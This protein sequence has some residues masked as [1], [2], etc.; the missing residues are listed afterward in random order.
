MRWPGSACVAVGLGLAMLAG[1]SLPL[2]RGVHVSHDVRAEQRDPGDIEVL[3]PGPRQRANPVDI[4]QG[5]LGAESSPENGHAIARQYLTADAH[6][7]DNEVQV[8][9]PA[10]L[11]V[12]ESSSDPSSAT[13]A[14]TFTKLGL[15]G[16]DGA[17]SDLVPSPVKEGYTLVR[18]RAGDW[19]ISS[20]P[21]GLRLTPADRDRSFRPRRLFY[22]SP[23]PKA[24]L[25]VVPDLVLLPVATGQ[26]QAAIS[27]LLQPP[28]SALQGSVTTA[29]PV[30]TRLLSL[31][32]E[33]G[34]LYDVNLSAELEH[35]SGPQ[36]QGLSAQLVWTLRGLDPRFESLRV[37]AAGKPFAVPSEGEVQKAEDWNVLDPEGLADGPL[38]FIGGG[39]L[40]T[41]TSAGRVGAGPAAS[42]GLDVDRAA[43]TPDRTQIALLHRDGG[44]VTVRAGPVSSDRYPVVLRAPG[45]SSPTWGSGE[46][47]LWLLDGSGHVL[48]LRGTGRA[49]PVVVVGLSTRIRSIAV[50]RDGARVAL[51]SDGL[52]YVGRI[53]KAA[54]GAPVVRPVLV[55]PELTGVTRVGWRDGTTLV[56]LGV[57]MD[58]FV[59]VLLSVDGSSVRSLAVSG[60]PSKPGELAAS[61]LG[62]V[63]TASGQL[64]VLSALGFQAGPPGAAPAYPG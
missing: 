8:Y 13:V 21:F 62:T 41:V 29:F 6:W 30:G 12:A 35:A 43:V 42:A 10:S 48:L 32:A 33:P 40:K 23:S 4:V 9:D 59:P 56:A 31:R 1:C 47:G 60:L 39:R 17:Y 44:T 22:L 45:L 15:L 50:S 64:F 54:N 24:T 36:R 7:A 55:A 58:T 11:R 3:P 28:S 26:V 52:L 49:V 53:T 16:K 20:P 57:L 5:F 34:G 37:L 14:V 61:S 19:R 2:P 18:G 51:V 63:V 38:Y 27:R 46:L 25:H